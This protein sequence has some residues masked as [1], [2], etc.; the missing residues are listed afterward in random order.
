MVV[1]HG[2]NADPTKHWFPWLTA[3]LAG[4]GIAVDVVALPD[5]SDPQLAAW[6]AAARTAIGAPAD[7][8]AIVGHSLGAVTALHAL[9]T[10]DDDWTLGALV[11]VAGFVEPLATLPQLTPFV[12]DVPDI[13]RTVTRAHRRAVLLSDDDDRVAPHATRNLGAALAADVFELT[14]HGHFLD[15]QGI[16][17]LPLLA[18]YLRR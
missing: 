7:D 2:Y 14:G 13:A 17:A 6:V 3:E 8:L 10:F 15:R 16:T 9:D 1:L 12:A 11:G 4:D 18:D 5:S